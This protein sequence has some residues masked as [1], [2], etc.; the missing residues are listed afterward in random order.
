MSSMVKQTCFLALLASAG[1]LIPCAADAQV[2]SDNQWD[3]ARAALRAQGPTNWAYAIQRWKTLSSSNRFS[4][5]DYAGFVTGAPGF[6]D[7]DKLRRYAEDAL[8]REYVEPARL[9][10]F[11]DRF[12]PLTNPGRAQYALALAALRRPEAETVARA[13]WRG[14]PMSDAAEAS[15][16]SQFYAKFTVDDHDARMDQLLWAGAQAQAERQL[17]FVSPARRV[18]DGARLAALRGS[19]PNA[20]QSTV[21]TASLM[22]DPGYVYQ[23]ARQ[24]RKAGNVS[25]ARYLLATRP[26]LSRRPAD[27]EKWVEELLVNAKGAAS[28]G[29]TRTAVRIAQGID[30]AFA[31]GT[32]IAATSS[33]G[34]RD[35]YTSLVWLGGTQ[36]LWNLRDPAA[37]A[38]L[39]YKYG[40]AA[41]TPQTRSKGFYWAGLAAERAKDN[42]SA[43][44]YLEMAAKYPDYFYGQLALERLGRPL[45]NFPA[46]PSAVPTQAERVAFNTSPLTAAVR[47]VARESDWRTAIR[48]FREIADRAQ[49]PGQHKLVAELAQALGRRDLGVITGQAAG[50]DGFLDFQSIAFPRIPVPAGYSQNW[51]MIHALIRQESQFAQNAVSHAGARGLMQLMP[52]TAREQAGKIGLSYSPDSLMGDPNYNIQLGSG[53]FVRMMSYYNGS[54]PLAIAAY[55]AGPG[56]VNKWLAANGDPRSG[57]ISWVDWIERIPLYETKNYVQRVIE[58]AVVYN[59]LNPDRASY[60]GANPASYFLGKRTPG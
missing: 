33:L 40:A 60:R 59:H 10:A 23:R 52:G 49:T 34:L 3:Q 5:G 51:T 19:D 17:G 26:P 22:S 6:P 45:P 4:F 11:F 15:L 25:N 21:E 31:P 2:T 53:Y 57:A 58:N 7:E 38:P 44:R 32:D 28:D 27:A 36:A 41:K 54:Y 39:F 29:D 30:E 14:G 20:I 24:L 1:L 16:Y 18:V 43:G 13:A 37:A 48:F 12:P 9:V 46:A 47:E 8:S 56:N 42:V 55:N 50:A 35:D